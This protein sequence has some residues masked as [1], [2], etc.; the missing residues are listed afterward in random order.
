MH[1]PLLAEICSSL[2]S[3]PYHFLFGGLILIGGCLR[4]INLWLAKNGLGPFFLGLG[5]FH[6]SNWFGNFSVRQ[7]IDVIRNLAYFSFCQEK[8]KYS[9]GAKLFR[10]KKSF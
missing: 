2:W 5:I 9:S 10:N 8:K 7:K 1:I 4:I 3:C 6:S